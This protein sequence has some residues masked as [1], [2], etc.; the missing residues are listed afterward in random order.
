MDS[1]PL[2]NYDPVKGNFSLEMSSMTPMLV[3]I[4]IPILY[5]KWKINLFQVC[6]VILKDSDALPLLKCPISL[7][8]V[9]TDVM[10]LLLAF[11]VYTFLHFP[12]KIIFH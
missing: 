7:F 10:M 2:Q 11:H 4:R 9:K 1:A 5:D 8:N 3:H 12:N 6:I